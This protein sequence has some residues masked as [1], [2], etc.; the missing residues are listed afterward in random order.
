MKDVE[1]EQLL[2]LKQNNKE[3]F[4][5]HLYRYC[6]LKASM[7][8]EDNIDGKVFLNIVANIITMIDEV[9]LF[10]MANL[11]RFLVELEDDIK[12]HN[13]ENINYLYLVLYQLIEEYTK[14]LLG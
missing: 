7:N 5:K 2:E 10:D 13:Y 4:D 14:R 9:K 8:K 3:E 1:L 11:E 12:Q 6:S